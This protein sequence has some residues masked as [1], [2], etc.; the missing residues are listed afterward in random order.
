MFVYATIMVGMPSEFCVSVGDGAS[1]GTS[2]EVY[3]GSV[4][5]LGIAILLVGSREGVARSPGSCSVAVNA[6]AADRTKIPIFHHPTPNS[7]K[8]K[9]ADIT[10]PI[11][12]LVFTGVDILNSSGNGSIRLLASTAQCA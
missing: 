4:N 1:V 9:A 5:R 10:T 7:T 2:V 6:G 3:L 11:S 12:F 8:I